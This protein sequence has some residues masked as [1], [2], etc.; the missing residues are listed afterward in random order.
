[1][2]RGLKISPKNSTPLDTIISS[3]GTVYA[4][5][6]LGCLEAPFLQKVV[7]PQ[8]RGSH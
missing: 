6:E 7:P 1:V 8:I 2:A 4:V 3:V 5:P